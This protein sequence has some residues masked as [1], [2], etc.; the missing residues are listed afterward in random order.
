MGLV[1]AS[2][3]S[4]WLFDAICRGREFNFKKAAVGLL[5]FW[6]N[7]WIE[8][9]LTAC[10]LYFGNYVV[11]LFATNKNAH[12]KLQQFLSASFTDILLLYLRY[13]FLFFSFFWE[14]GAGLKEKF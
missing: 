2:L 14:G 7:G 12:T 13:I 3:Q 9:F 5:V 8:E 1:S 6:A 11:Y 10:D 4:S